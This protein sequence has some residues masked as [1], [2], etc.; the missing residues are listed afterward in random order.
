VNSVSDKQVYDKINVECGVNRIC[1]IWFLPDIYRC[2]S[3]VIVFHLTIEFYT[4][5]EFISVSIRII[6][7]SFIGQQC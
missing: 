7:R 1:P 2:E 4:V 6:F 3:S 5:E